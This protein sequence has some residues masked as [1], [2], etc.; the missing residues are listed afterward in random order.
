VV[1]ETTGVERHASLDEPSGER[2]IPEGRGPVRPDPGV[3]QESGRT[4][5]VEPRGRVA[6]EDRATV[7]L[8]AHGGSESNV[9]AC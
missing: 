9:R 6:D 1:T 4:G 3:P 5:E 7:E 2:R 8:K